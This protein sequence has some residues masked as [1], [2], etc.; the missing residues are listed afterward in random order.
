MPDG[1]RISSKYIFQ[2]I[3]DLALIRSEKNV[4]RQDNESVDKLDQIYDENFAFCED[5]FPDA[6]SNDFKN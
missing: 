2:N 6:F 4:Y 5:D 1:N 3:A